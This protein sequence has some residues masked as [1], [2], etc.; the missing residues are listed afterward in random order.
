MKWY[1]GYHSLYQELALVT[2]VA[3]VT[4]VAWDSMQSL[5][6]DYI[7]MT[8]KRPGGLGKKR[9]LL[10]WKRNQSGRNIYGYLDWDS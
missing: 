1:N 9:W 8:T 10:R 7:L 6:D 3:Q 4:Q 2:Q 5:Q